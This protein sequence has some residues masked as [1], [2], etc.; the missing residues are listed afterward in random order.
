MTWIGDGL[1]E[2]C[3][4]A[5]QSGRRMSSG[6]ITIEP[7]PISWLSQLPS[8]RCRQ[9]YQT[10]FS[11]FLHHAT[12]FLRAVRSILQRF[13]NLNGKLINIKMRNARTV[14]PFGNSRHYANYRLDAL[15]RVS[16][17]QRSLDV[18]LCLASRAQA[19][20]GSSNDQMRF[21][22]LEDFLI[23]FGDQVTPGYHS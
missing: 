11:P 21:L 18:T 22:R 7:T 10:L 14:S 23:G 1:A 4:S 16:D 6:W 5:F 8:G 13:A 3:K 15:D 19:H 20:D 12:Q 17:A 2:A 9:R